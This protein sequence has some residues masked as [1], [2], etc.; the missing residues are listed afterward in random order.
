M[1]N[2]LLPIAK[3][4]WGYTL[5]AIL[6]FIIFAILDL[7]FLQFLAFIATAFFVFVFRNPEREHPYY[8]ENSVVSPVDGVV[9]SID[10]FKND[11]Y[12]YR[13]EINSTYL[14]VSQ[15][16]VP[17]SST[18]HSIEKQN[19]ARLSRFSSLS[20]SINENTELTFID[21]N[22]NRLKIIHR[23]KQSFMGIDIKALKSQKLY[24]GS[25]YGLMINGVTTLYLPKNFRLNVNVGSE[26][27]ASETL[28][29]Y[30][31]KEDKTTK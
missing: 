6:F 9:S 7:G 27:V 26:L 11:E 22:S 2:N 5:G 12:A 15:L 1:K 17:F 13:L 8:Q 31:T 20:K 14:N 28:V 29:G 16:R 24:Q 30:F 18:L 23:L 19:G 4:G 21:K 3:Q 25:R 10:E